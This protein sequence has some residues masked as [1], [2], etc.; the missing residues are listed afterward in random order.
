MIMITMV[1]VA[2]VMVVTLV[3]M[4]IMRQVDVDHGR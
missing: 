3:V 4:P 2:L 1:I